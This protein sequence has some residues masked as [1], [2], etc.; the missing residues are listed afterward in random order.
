MLTFLISGTDRSFKIS[1][2]TGTT[3]KLSFSCMR[4]GS[5]RILVT[6]GENL[7]GFA[8]GT[9][10]GD[11]GPAIH[12][13]I[14]AREPAR[15]QESW[16]AQWN[17]T[18]CSDESSQLRKTQAQGNTAPQ[19]PCEPC[20]PGVYSS[21]LLLLKSV[22]KTHIENVGKLGYIFFPHGTSQWGLILS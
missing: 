20:R 19:M 14:T 7:E 15:G 6:W 16:P 8:L 3:G 4:K 13:K 5:L 2:S 18:E 21:L 12:R 17:V 11:S 1:Q 10:G 9:L 22:S